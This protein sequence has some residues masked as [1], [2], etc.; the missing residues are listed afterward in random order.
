MCVAAFA[1][2][3]DSADSVP[4]ED[5]LIKSS[6]SATKNLRVEKVHSLSFSGVDCD[7]Q[8][9]QAPYIIGRQSKWTSAS[10]S[11]LMINV[12][13]HTETIQL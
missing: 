6:T 9:A 2:D 7:A 11:L 3:L 1:V 10:Y 12:S 13:K 4:L 5:I 8:W